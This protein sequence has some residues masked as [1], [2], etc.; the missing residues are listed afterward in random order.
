MMKLANIDSR[1][2]SLAL[3]LLNG[4][5][6]IRESALSVGHRKEYVWAQEEVFV[7]KCL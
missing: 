2:H 5:E 3:L 1:F 7:F 6:E 4:L